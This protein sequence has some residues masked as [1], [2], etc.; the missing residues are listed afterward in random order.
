MN[1]EI[2]QQMLND[3]IFDNRKASIQKELLQ[4]NISLMVSYNRESNFIKG[5]H[6]LILNLK[7]N[8]NKFSILKLYL[9]SIYKKLLLLIS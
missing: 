5:L 4:Q 2:L 6:Q 9:Y 7:V 1:I 3:P 8:D